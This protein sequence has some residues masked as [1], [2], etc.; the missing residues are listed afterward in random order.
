MGDYITITW[1]ISQEE[2]RKRMAKMLSDGLVCN[3]CNSMFTHPRYF[4]VGYPV[5]LRICCVC[6]NIWIYYCQYGEE[7]ISKHYINR[8]K[9]LKKLFTLVI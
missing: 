6:R 4:P 2:A 3:C 5:K 7:I 8:L 1:G 9:Y